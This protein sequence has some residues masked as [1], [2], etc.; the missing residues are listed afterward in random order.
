[1]RF[2]LIL[3][4]LFSLSS[5]AETSIID[6]MAI[7]KIQKKTIFYSDLKNYLREYKSFRCLQKSS[8]ILKNLRIDQKNIRKIPN[9]LPN[10]KSLDRHQTFIEGLIKLIKLQVYSSRYNVSISKKQLSRINTKKCG[11]GP[12]P[13]WSNELKSLFQMEYYILERFPTKRKGGDK[14]LTL[15]IQSVD[16]KIDHDIFY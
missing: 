11:V 13:K 4:L 2:S 16:E 5:A 14:E 10:Y 1:M 15:F 7:F 8:R 12:F 9:V 6:D 3:G